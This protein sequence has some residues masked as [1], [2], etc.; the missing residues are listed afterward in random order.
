MVYEFSLLQMSL[1]E[2]YKNEMSKRGKPEKSIFNVY[3]YVSFCKKGKGRRNELSL[4]LS[5]SV[6]SNFLC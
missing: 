6:S 5:P 3:Y 1:H 4:T 2:R